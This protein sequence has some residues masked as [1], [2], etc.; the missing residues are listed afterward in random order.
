MKYQVELSATAEVAAFVTV[1]ARKRG[2]G[3]CQALGMSIEPN[4]WQICGTPDSP[5]V[6]CCDLDDSEEI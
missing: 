1:D 5:W 3:V 6:V 2:G 4:Q